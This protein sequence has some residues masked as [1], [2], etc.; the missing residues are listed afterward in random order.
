M[1][2]KRAT[3][4]FPTFASSQQLFLHFRFLASSFIASLTS[5][6]YDAAIGENFDAF[7]KK[8][9]NSAAERDGTFSDAFT[10]ADYHSRVMDDILS[11][12]LLRSSQ[13]AVGDV[14]RGVLDVILEFGILMSDRQRGILKEY[15]TTE[16]LEE[17]F[18][19]FRKRFR[20]LVSLTLC[21]LH[22]RHTKSTSQMKA[23]RAIVDKGSISSHIPLEDALLHF[24]ADNPVSPQLFGVTAKLHNLLTR[25][26]VSMWWTRQQQ[27]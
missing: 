11:A 9:E 10:L 5:Y 26:D 16:P 25:L 21:F 7:L 15:Q 3:P 20:T 6:V 27:S 1:T 22:A 2:L 8:L 19:K 18:G 4:P 24:S 23:L 14:L 17:L 13:K 12:C